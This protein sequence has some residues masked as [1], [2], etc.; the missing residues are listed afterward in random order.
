MAEDGISESASE[1]DADRAPQRSARVTERADDARE[2]SFDVVRTATRSL[3]IDEDGDAHAELGAAPIVD[4]DADGAGRTA[5]AADRAGERL[6]P[7]RLIAKLGEGGMGVVYAAEDARLGRMVALKILPPAAVASPDKRRRFLR[8]ARAASAVMHPGIAAVFEVGEHRG[9]VFLA[10]ER[11]EGKTLR[12]VLRER[13]GPLPVERALAVA[14]DIARA[15]E[16]AHRAGV[17]HRDLKPENVM[18]TPGGAVKILDFGLAKRIGDAAADAAAGGDVAT[19]EG[20]I[21]GTPGYMAPEQVH[22]GAV[23]ARTDIFALGVVLFELLTA[24]RPFRGPSAIAQIAAIERDPAPAPSAHAASVPASVDAIVARC[25]EKRPEDRF[26]SCGE[27]AAAIEDALAGMA[28]PARARW[29]WIAAMIAVAAAAIGVWR[30]LSPGPAGSGG[31]GAASG[32]AVTSSAGPAGSVS[33]GA[34]VASGA[35]ATPPSSSALEPSAPASPRRPCLPSDRGHAQCAIARGVI[36]WCDPAGALVACCGNGLVPK[37]ADG[38]CGCAPGGTGVAEAR[39]R[40]CAAVPEGAADAFRA[41]KRGA[42]DAAIACFV[43]IARDKRD[44]GAFA[45]EFFLTPEGEVFGARVEQCTLPDEG[46]QRCALAAL[47]STRFPPPA[48][49]EAGKKLGFGFLF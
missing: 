20:K 39:N 15:L 46:A 16:H 17:V 38:V 43:P 45:A 35:A 41:A 37:G 29:G 32:T 19:V 49:E 6:G 30:S 14:R 24:E 26:A 25:L 5:G 23:D 27:L 22:G 2:R 18:E 8:E 10:M 3:E 11:V 28:P 4:A 34:P 13:G 47:R 7:F 12:A 33:S 40:G 48:A 44:G 9:E 1:S 21:L 42:M 36:A 31:S